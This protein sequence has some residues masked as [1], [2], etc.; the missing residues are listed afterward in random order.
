EAAVLQ[1]LLDSYEGFSDAVQT[2]LHRPDWAAAPKTVTDVIACDPELRPA[3]HA[4]LGPFADCLVVQNEA[5]AQAGIG[6]LR[7]EDAGRATFI[8]LERLPDRLHAVLSPTPPGTRPATELVRTEPAYRPLVRLLLQNYFVA[9][10]LAQ[11]EALREQYAVARFVTPSGE[12]TSARGVT[13]AGGADRSATAERLGRREQLEAA[14]ARQDAV[15][16]EI[17]RAEEDLRRLR[18]AREALALDARRADLREAERAFDAATREAAQAAY[19]REAHTARRAELADR[20]ED[21]RAQREE[22]EHTTALDRAL[23]AAQA[24]YAEAQHARA[25]AEA[26]A[27]EA[28]A[29]GRDALARHAEAHVEAAQAASRLDALRRDR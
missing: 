6:R 15:R 27:D 13:H 20:L 25:A 23:A 1:S 10:S 24:R 4:A 14:V 19:E 22:A 21:L 11:A 8:V 16:A 3:I 12:W 18:E 5:E 9:D 29:V 2:L 17:E 26:A 7:D 28:E